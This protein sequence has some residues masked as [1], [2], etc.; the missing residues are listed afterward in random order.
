MEEV[1]AQGI[2]FHL[3]LFGKIVGNVLMVIT[4]FGTMSA[5][6]FVLVVFIFI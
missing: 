3:D 1:G 6:F 2:F 4:F 5:F